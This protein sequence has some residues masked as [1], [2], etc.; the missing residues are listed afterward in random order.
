MITPRPS[1]ICEALVPPVLPLGFLTVLETLENGDDLLEGSKIG[2]HLSGD[3]GGVFTELDVEILAVRAGAHGG[4]E[5]GT[6]EET[7][8]RL[9]SG[10]VGTAE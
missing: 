3:L 7:M 9:K 6:D 1:L 4:G 10:A 8:V 2:A 5:D